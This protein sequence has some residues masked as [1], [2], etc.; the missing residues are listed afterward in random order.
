MSYT[1]EELHEIAERIKQYHKG[2]E[3][4]I[5]YKNP[6]TGEVT[7]YTV[8]LDGDDRTRLQNMANDLKP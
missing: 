6:F 1:T 3:K 7:V 8:P 2:G 4:E 5:A